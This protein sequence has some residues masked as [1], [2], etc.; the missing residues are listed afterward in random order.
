[1]VKRST[2]NETAISTRLT[3]AGLRERECSVCG[4]KQTEVIPKLEN[5]D[6]IIDNP[7]NYSGAG[8]ADAEVAK[9]VIPVTDEEKAAKFST[10]AIAY[11]DV[12]NAAPKFSADLCTDGRVH[13]DKTCCFVL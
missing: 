13:A 5:G 3:E 2:T 6:I 7:G 10:Y 11:A 8:I 9:S 1:M 12:S 4:A